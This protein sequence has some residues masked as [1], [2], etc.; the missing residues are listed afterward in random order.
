[1]SP[2]TTLTKFK[3]ALNSYNE[4][5]AYIY[6]Y[7]L[8]FIYRDQLPTNT[9]AFTAQA[10]LQCP[11]LTQQQNS[12]GK[13]QQCDKHNTKPQTMIGQYFH[14]TIAQSYKTQA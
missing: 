1:M 13:I 14:K 5:P 4:L 6:I 7:I 9:T 8:M 12:T 2:I 3:A 11:N 10:S